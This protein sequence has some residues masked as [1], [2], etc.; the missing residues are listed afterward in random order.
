MKFQLLINTKIAKI[1]KKIQ[2][3]VP[4]RMCGKQMGHFLPN[5]GTGMVESIGEYI[6]E[7]FVSV[8][9]GAAVEFFGKAL[10][11]FCILVAGQC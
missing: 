4:E 10:S 2:Y 3:P 6:L 9:A 1:N 8:R 11:P 5:K 7:Q